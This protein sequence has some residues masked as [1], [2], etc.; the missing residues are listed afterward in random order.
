MALFTRDRFFYRSFIK[1]LAFVALQNI[2]IYSVNLADTLMLGAFSQNSLSGAALANQ[3]QFLLQMIVNGIADGLLVLATQYWGTKRTGPIKKVV[4]SA[5]R[6]GA[7]FVLVFFIGCLFFPSQI[8]GVFTTDPSVIFQGAQ[9][10]R[11]LSFTFPFFFLTNIFIST[12]RSVENVGF[13]MW[14]S[15]AALVVNVTLNAVLI[16]GLLGFPPMGAKGAAIATLIARIVEFFVGLGYLLKKDPHLKMK[17]KDF[18]TIDKILHKDFM[19]ISTPVVLSGASWGIAMSVQTM[20]L[21]RMG[22]NVVSANAIATAVFQVCTVIAYGGASAAGI[23]I[24]KTV[25]QGD[26]AKTKEYT[27]TLQILFVLLG[28]LTSAFILLFKNPIIH[29]YQNFSDF[30]PQ[31]LTLANGFITV[32]SITA[33]GT[34]YQVACLTGI[35][36]SGGNTKFV[37]YNDLIFMWGLVLPSALLAAFVFH[38]SPMVIFVILKSDQILKCFVALVYVNS[39]KWIKKLTRVDI[40]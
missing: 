29:F 11:I 23:I 8:I 15:I 17:V 5:L 33:I 25:G 10:L 32:L 40:A 6:Y 18:F 28:L 19:K 12:Q 22:S 1:L 13:G 16:F 21:G 4:A 30:T 26:V 27:K 9:Y 7:P 24:G 31:A 2:L 34:A 14:L 37:F 36:R 3:V 35:V 38:W 20:I 39:Y